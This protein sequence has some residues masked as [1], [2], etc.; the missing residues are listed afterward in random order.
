MRDHKYIEESVL[1]FWKRERIYQ[2]QKEMLK[3]AEKFEF[4]DGP[5]YA[6][7]QI[8]PGTGWNKC[9]KDFVLRYMRAK[10]KYAFAEPGYDTH[11]LPIEVKVEQKLN[12]KFKKDIEEKIGIARF[13]E[14]CKSYATQYMGIM[15]SDFER[16]GVWMDYDTPYITYT[17][18][19]IER[20]WAALKEVWDKG[21]MY[22]S[23]YVLANCPRCETTLAN[24]ELE[25]EDK[26]SPSIYV[27]FKVLGTENEYLVIWTTTPWTLVANMAVMVNPMLE[28]VK[29]QVDNEKWIV[30]KDRLESFV[31]EAR[32]EGV[33]LLESFAGK[34]L[35]G[36]RYAHPLEGMIGKDYDRRV[37]MSDEY[38][39]VEEG[40]GLVHVAPG[41]GPEDFAIGKRYGIEIYCPVDEKGVYDSTAGKYTGKRVLDVNDE[42]ISDLKERG[43]IVAKGVK[44]H[45]YPHCWRCKTPLIFISSKQWFIRISSI[46]DKMLEEIEKISWYP[47]FARTRFRDFVLN[48][49]DWC[50]SRQRYWGI[51]LPI[52]KCLK[53]GSYATIGSKKELGK[54]VRELHRPYIDEIKLRCQKCSGEMERIKDILDVW[55]DS[56]N[57]VWASAL[58]KDRYE[59]D[60]ILEGKDQTRGWFY[61]LLG[62]GITYK[63]K[64][65]YKSVLMHGFF[66][67]SKGEKMSK[68]LGNYVPLNEIIEK[69]GADAFRFWSLSSTPWDDLKFSWIDLENS[70][71]SLEIIHNMC[72][73]LKRFYWA[74]D[75]LSLGDN[76]KLKVEDRWILS[77]LNSVI[78]Q[79]DEYNS[80]F[81]F[82]RSARLLE[83]FLVEEVSRT[84]LKLC[85]ERIEKKE[86]AATYVLYNVIFTSLKL[87]SYFVPFMTE[88]EYQ[89]FFRKFEKQKSIHYFEFPR[90]NTL[91]IDK[92]LE[93]EMEKILE[94]KSGIINL[95][96][97]KRLNLRQPLRKAVVY[98]HSASLASA[99]RNF[100]H[101]LKQL[102][103]VKEV[104]YRNRLEGL[105]VD[106]ELKENLFG[107]VFK[108]K[109]KEA[110]NKLSKVP[111]SELLS[112]LM[113]Y[114]YVE[115]M[116]NKLTED[117]FEFKL[118]R[119][120]LVGCYVNGVFAVID[121]NIDEDLQKEGLLKE[122]TRR[123]QMMRKQANLVEKD[124]IEFYVSEC[125]D[126]LLKVLGKEV[127]GIGKKAPLDKSDLEAEWEIKG[128]KYTVQIRK[129]G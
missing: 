112:Q 58:T 124:S 84:Y 103:N 117:F 63:G 69:Y 99:L 11:G 48:A 43:Y 55:F 10:G 87:L 19:Y 28:Y 125:E 26:K 56:G 37:V 116:G 40:T 36:L 3:D 16:L 17:D 76:Q 108:E 92:E 5:P 79:V 27:K 67:D 46:K 121:T 96:N 1:D 82:H 24:Y 126:E 65:P 4:V 85:K 105:E 74:K 6:T 100:S 34:K 91:N 49:P 64:S 50:I 41:H 54:E 114:Q 38:V 86:E 60:F 83:N 12:L 33:I 78:A 23:V 104:E 123:I 59:V 111:V 129:I 14:E 68:S 81:E 52:W 18:D 53:C 110:I 75:K 32:L 107:Q 61:S 89:D 120:G 70:A 39:S 73:Y 7:G 127:N 29:V 113:T 80:S 128:F 8:H 71:K 51:P 88:Y 98:S 57:A 20:T 115:C 72:V 119:K 21:L 2:K 109:S 118:D 106:L 13:V 95:R 97:K 22:E 77:R 90:V 25:Y 31:K 44:V 35:D 122:L 30:A 62:M 42:I 9:M 66:V 45:R 94:I 47:D 102:I 15:N 93:Q 101:I